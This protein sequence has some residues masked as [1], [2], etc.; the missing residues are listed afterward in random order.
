MKLN[1][2]K[3]LV[4]WITGLPGSGKTTIAK[5]IKKSIELK[6]GKTILFSGDDLRKILNFLDYDKEKRLVYSKSY[7][8]LIKNLSNQNLNVIIATVALFNEIHKWNRKNIQN[9]C[10]IFIKTNISKIKSHKKKKLY[11]EKKNNLVGIDIKPE[12]PLKPDIKIIN[13]FDK[14]IDTLSKTIL[15]KFIK[16]L[17]FSFF[18]KIWFCYFVIFNKKF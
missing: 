9:Y 11:F 7:A 5:K 16:N 17:L 10:E 1:K 4:F 2:K 6:Y 12:F 8:Y 18:P 3:G 13:N 14:S 15:K